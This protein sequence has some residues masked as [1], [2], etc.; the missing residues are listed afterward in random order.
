MH[1]LQEQYLKV[2]K[3]QKKVAEAQAALEQAAIIRDSRMRIEKERLEQSRALVADIRGVDHNLFSQ[4][5]A[6]P[7]KPPAQ[8]EQ[9]VRMGGKN[10]NRVTHSNPVLVRFACP[11]HAAYPLRSSQLHPLQEQGQE[12]MMQQAQQLLQAQQVMQMQQVSDRNSPVPFGS[13]WSGAE[14]EHGEK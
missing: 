13:A 1:P 2:L 10:R 11:L 12:C 4:G 7:S 8:L 14:G 5:A 9:K 6:T 3:A